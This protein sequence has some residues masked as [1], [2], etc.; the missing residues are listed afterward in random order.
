MTPEFVTQLIANAPNFIGFVLLAYVQDR[1]NRRLIE[2][3]DRLSQRYDDL[4][5][6]L[7]GSRVMTPQEA[8]S[9]RTK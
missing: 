9:L 7:V 4:V 6:T 5:D 8:K 1:N 3:Y 2:M